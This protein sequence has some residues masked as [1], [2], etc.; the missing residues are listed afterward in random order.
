MT[1]LLKKLMMTPGVSGREYKIREVIRAEAEKYADEVTTDPMGNLI[2]RK[3][4]NGK[5]IMLVAHMDEIGYFATYI[6][7]DGLIHLGAVGGI[8]PMSSAYD[9][10]VS[11]RGVCGVAV[12]PDNTDIP[13]AEKLLVD[14]GVKT[15]KQA[16]AKVSIGD[17]FVHS[18]RL[19]R[20]AG[21]R[22]VGRPFD[23]RAGCLVL[24]E[25]LKSVKNTENDLY[26]VFSVQEEV[27]SRGA[28]PAAYGIEPDIG[29]AVD[30]T[31]VSGKPASKS[32]SK[33]KLGQGAAIKIKDSSVICSYELVEIMRRLAEERRIKCQDEI[34]LAG[35][36]DT[37]VI[38]VAKTGC[39]AGAL[40]IPTAYI[41]TVNEMIDIS[42]VREAVKLTVAIAERI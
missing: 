7:S 9:T 36:T 37:S 32:A 29:I 40:S 12:P 39:Q 30:V 34:I 26:F 16:E 4:G 6:D 35:G 8:N 38:Q 18:P 20:L 27:G 17:F 13:K 22:Y 5:K 15:R 28:K 11:E 10:V 3:K 23:D 31:T 2:A 19:K 14:I 1:E 33:V 24:L 25:A 42:D 21:N 41:H